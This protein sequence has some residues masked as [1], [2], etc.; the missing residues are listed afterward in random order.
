MVTK[1][2]R[3][4]RLD[5]IRFYDKKLN[6][7]VYTYGDGEPKSRRKRT[8]EEQKVDDAGKKEKREEKADAKK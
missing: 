3:L 1:R 4:A 7:H 2:K 8:K 5:L 6:E